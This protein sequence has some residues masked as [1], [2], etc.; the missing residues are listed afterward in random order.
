MRFT[1][2]SAWVSHGSTRVFKTIVGADL[3]AKAAAEAGSSVNGMVACVCHTWC[4]C[5]LVRIPVL[6]DL[7]RNCN[8]KSVEVGPKQRGI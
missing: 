8:C 6:V 2:L 5:G 4:V 1:R 7:S 3:G